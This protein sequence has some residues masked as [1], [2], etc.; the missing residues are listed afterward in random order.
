VGVDEGAEVLDATVLEG[1]TTLD[2]G[3]LDDAG[4]LEEIDPEEPQFP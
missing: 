4:T 1:G 2:A 3:V